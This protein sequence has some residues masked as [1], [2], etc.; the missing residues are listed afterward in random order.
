[1]KIFFFGKNVFLITSVTTV[2]TVTTDT[3]VPTYRHIG[4]L[5]IITS[6]TVPTVTIT[7]VTINQLVNVT[8]KKL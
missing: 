4:R 3:T 1:M 6:V 7:T 8:L 2:S 5:V